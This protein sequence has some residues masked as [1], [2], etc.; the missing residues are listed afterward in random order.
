LT[1]QSA[2]IAISAFCFKNADKEAE[3]RYIFI[4]TPSVRQFL[5]LELKNLSFR[6]EMIIVHGD[7]MS[8]VE[9]DLVGAAGRATKHCFLLL[10]GSLP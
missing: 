1:R 4:A 7:S 2:N 3:P 5:L 9:T 8:G 10:C 6:P